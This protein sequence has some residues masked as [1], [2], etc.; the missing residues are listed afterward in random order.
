MRTILLLNSKGGCGKSTLATNL[1]GYYASRGKSVVLA[2]FDPQG[3]SMDW[4]AVR[5]SDRPEIKGIAA[6]EE[7]LR[8]PKT[9]EY[10]IMDSPAALRDKPL[11]DLVRRAESIL[12]PLLPSPMDMRA[13]TRFL[14]TLTEIRRILNNEVKLATIANRVRDH[15]IAAGNLSDYLHALKL[16]DGH[17]FPFLAVLRASQN[18]VHAAERGLSIFEFARSATL[19]DR[20]QWK[21]L[22]RW[23]NSAR[24]IPQ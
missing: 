2:D 12:I 20:E 13:A 8:V 19:Q 17:H 9:T 1:A 23:L 22:L 18:Y 6:W 10:L 15:T 16:P 11:V 5:P 14:E 7:P 21:P 24:S 4:L 3:S